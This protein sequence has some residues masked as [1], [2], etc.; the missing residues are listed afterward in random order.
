MYT[1]QNQVSVDC[2]I[3]DCNSRL[4]LFE[5]LPTSPYR[6]TICHR[7]SWVLTVPLRTFF[8][9]PLTLAHCRVVVYMYMYRS[10]CM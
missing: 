6:T 1:H 9:R 2:M 10:L 4:L 5:L 3:K 8:H 7:E